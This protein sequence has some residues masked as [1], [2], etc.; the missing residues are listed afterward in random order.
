MDRK[1][2][3]PCIEVVQMK[4]GTFKLCK[5]ELWTVNG[6]RSFGAILKEIRTVRHGS[7]YTWGA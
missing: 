4:D 2:L 5:I 7:D 6:E 1:Y 3:G